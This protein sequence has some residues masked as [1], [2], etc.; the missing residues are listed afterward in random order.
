MSADGSQSIGKITK[1]WS[2]ASKEVHTDAD[3][4]GI[5]CEFHGHV[6][7][8]WMTVRLAGMMTS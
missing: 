2:G 4:F 7:V 5:Q 6:V 1:Q 3:N 8:V